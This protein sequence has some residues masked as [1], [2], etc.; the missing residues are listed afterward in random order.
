MSIKNFIGR[1]FAIDK[2]LHFGASFFITI[3]V[4]AIL[5]AFGVASTIW[6]GMGA[7]LLVGI[8]KEVADYFLPNHSAE[9]GDLLADLAGILLAFV[10]YLCSFIQ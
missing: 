10:C 9:W 8:G 7:A 1:A 3:I 5:H 4:C 6:W 2:R